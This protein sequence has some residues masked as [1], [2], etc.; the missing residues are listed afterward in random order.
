MNVRVNKYIT[1]VTYEF[2]DTYNVSSVTDK[3]LM[4]E[5]FHKITGLLLTMNQFSRL[6]RNYLSLR[7]M[8]P[9]YRSDQ[10]SSNRLVVLVN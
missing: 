10:S 1:G 5:Q 3:Q 4:L 7:D 9:I 8:K 6:L 2:F